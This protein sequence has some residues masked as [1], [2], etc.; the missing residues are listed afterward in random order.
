MNDDL[1]VHE[2][3]RVIGFIGL[4]MEAFAV[5]KPKMCKTPL[6]FRAYDAAMDHGTSAVRKL[7]ALL[8]TQGL[9]MK[10]NPN[11]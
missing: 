6:D 8:E 11:D 9:T 4:G 5:M 7:T 3:E 1:T 10:E 2:I